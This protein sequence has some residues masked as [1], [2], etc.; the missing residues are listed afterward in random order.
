MT[1]FF[2]MYCKTYS[3]DIERL[4][5]MLQS[6]EQ[7]NKDNI[8]M[9]ISVPDAETNL[10]EEFQNDNV[11]IITDESYAKEYFA[12]Q[13][14]HGFGV[15][16]VNQEICKLSFFEAGLLENYLCIDSDVIFIRDFFVNDF[17]RDKTTP[18]SV[19]V[20]DKDLAVEKHYQA[21]WDT[22]IEFI[23][24]IYDYVGLDDK[25]YRTCHGM[26]CMSAKV[27]SS[28]KKKFMQPK[29]LEYRDLIEISPFEFSW[30]NAWL[31]KSKIID[32]VAVEPFFK[33]FHMRIDYNFSRLKMIDKKDLARS[34]VGIILNSNWMIPPPKDY[35]NPSWLHKK[36]Y[37]IIKKK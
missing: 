34:Y 14:K 29:G 32:V 8:L 1:N 3:K 33:T 6:F 30:Y 4:K 22:R 31:Q 20:M 21:F 36:F 25:R 11:K 9:Y 12:T 19:L 16:Y 23:K 35:E 2:G 37:N 13:T 27:L 5:K 15:G 28:L 17:M 7:F 26:Q 24:K 10:F 18:Y